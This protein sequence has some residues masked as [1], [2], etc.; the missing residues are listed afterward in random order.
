MSLFL[1]FLVAGGS[2]MNRFSIEYRKTDEI[3]GIIGDI[4]DLKRQHWQYDLDEHREWMKKYVERDDNHVLLIQGD[5]LF[6][7]V[8]VVN[9]RVTT[10]EMSIKTLG[11]SNLCV[12]RA[13]VGNGFG[14][15]IMSCAN[16]LI[17]ELQCTGVLLCDEGNVGFYNKC[18]WEKAEANSVIAGGRV[19]DKSIM[20]YNTGYSAV[21][22]NKKD[23]VIDRWF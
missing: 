15:L 21:D 19:F 14:R 3:S 13:T 17:K 12:E 8:S 18:G 22:L 2:K 7:Y 23:I 6:G 10:T 9:I 16:V 4:I 5:R 1:R 11:I 20:T